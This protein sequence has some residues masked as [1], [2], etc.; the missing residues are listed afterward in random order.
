[1][2]IFDKVNS[3]MD[4]LGFTSND[5][6]PNA[7][8]IAKAEMALKA[9]KFLAVISDPEE[10]EKAITEALRQAYVEGIKTGKRT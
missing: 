3:F 4:D 6:S 8:L 10:R 1:M 9:A 7:D 2:D 5:D